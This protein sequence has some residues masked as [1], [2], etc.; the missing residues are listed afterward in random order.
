MQL[1]GHDEVLGLGGFH[2][3]LE[4]DFDGPGYGNSDSGYR[5]RGVEVLAG[6]RHPL[7]RTSARFGEGFLALFARCYLFSI[8]NHLCVRSCCLDGYDALVKAMLTT[9][10]VP[11]TVQSG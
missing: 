3:G 9:S 4:P 10:G 7:V 5:C 6:R 11:P 2:P 1:L 8:L